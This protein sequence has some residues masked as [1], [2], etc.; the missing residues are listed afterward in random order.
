[1]RRCVC[2]FLTLRLITAAE[3]KHSS[4]I[5]HLIY[6]ALAWLGVPDHKVSSFLLFLQCVALTEACRLVV[7]RHHLAVLWLLFEY[8]T[9]KCW[10]KVG[11]F[12]GR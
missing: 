2:I 10:E 8:R 12:F 5:A 3:G 11:N 1:M 7:G 9:E 4:E 6:W